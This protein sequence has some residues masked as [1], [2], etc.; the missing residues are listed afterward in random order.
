M[1]DFSVPT[2]DLYQNL[3]EI[4]RIN[5]QL[6]G[7][8]VTLNGLKQYFKKYNPTNTVSLADIGCGGGDTLRYIH[9]WAS[10]NKVN[11][12]LTGID[13]Q[14]VMTEY[15][16]K[17]SQN[18]SID[19]KL[20]SVFDIQEQ[21]DI[22]TCSLFCHHFDSDTLVQMLQKLCKVSR[23]L[24]LINDLHRHW[25]AYYS[26]KY[27]TKWFKGSYLVQHDAPLSVLRG[28]KKKEWQNIF[29]KTG[30]ENAQIRWKW[31][32]R[33]QILIWL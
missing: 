13:Y 16:R 8:K 5:I 14:P 11:I 25:L 4:E 7:H 33:H 9:T 20:Q 12:Q 30:I 31:A 23:H 29:Q 1:D 27:I 15:A 32:F 19:Y 3:K 28:F 26:I 10:K 21:Y 17:T 6:G 24:I 2:K 18:L 22:V